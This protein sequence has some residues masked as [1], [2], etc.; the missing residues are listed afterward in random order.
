MSSERRH[1][2]VLDELLARSVQVSRTPGRDAQA[3][4][5]PVRGLPLRGWWDGAGAEDGEDDVRTVRAPAGSGMP[6]E[7]QAGGREEPARG[8]GQAGPRARALVD[9]AETWE[10][11]RRPR[12]PIA[13][14]V[15]TPRVAGAAR[16]GA[17]AEV[18]VGR[19]PLAL[20][21]SRAATEERLAEAG[22]RLDH[23]R[24]ELHEAH[25]LL[26]ERERELAELAERLAQ[27]EG[28]L[29]EARAHALA[30]EERV[31]TIEEAERRAGEAQARAEEAGRALAAQLRQGAE[32]EAA[33]RETAESER[34]GREQ[35]E[36]ELARLRGG[37]LA[38]RPIVSDIEAAGAGD[39]DRPD[40]D[41]W[42]ETP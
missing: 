21:L 2:H 12:A 18:Q 19:G 28:R 3:S 22:E 14:D 38:L 24:R 40:R 4:G 30:A 1:R 26:G 31:A 16:R 5:R 8:G 36:I 37:L 29:G 9:D 6:G 15:R 13:R 17:N 32:R 10:G 11:V 39:G 42:S 34:A 20:H 27:A 41:R 23:S 35:A 7:A 25:D 33:L